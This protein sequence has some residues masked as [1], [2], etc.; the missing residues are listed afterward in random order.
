[1]DTCSMFELMGY[2]SHLNITVPQ[3]SEVTSFPYCCAS[4]DPKGIMFGTPL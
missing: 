1:M 4:T 2:L 3:I